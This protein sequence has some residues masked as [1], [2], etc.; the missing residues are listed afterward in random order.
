MSKIHEIY[1]CGIGEPL[2]KYDTVKAVAEHLRRSF[3]NTIFLGINTS[4]T[5]YHKIKSVDFARYFDLIQV[6][7]NAENEARYNEICRP[8][9]GGMYSTVLKFLDH[10]KEYQNS[11]KLKARIELSAVDT[12]NV[13]QLP[14]R[15]RNAGIKNA[16]FE[17]CKK[18]ANHFGWDFKVKALIENCES[19]VFNI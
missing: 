5:Y 17:E 14:K 13:D 19:S 1:F 4:G 9:I 7:L 12:S 2:L 18:I 11:E 15:E 16:N 8:K 3:G 6:S 10:L